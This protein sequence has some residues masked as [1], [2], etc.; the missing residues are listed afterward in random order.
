MAVIQSLGAL[1]AQETTWS[2]SYAYGSLRMYDTYGYDYAT[3]YKTQPNIRTCVDFLARNIAQLGLH[4]F[5]RKGETDRVRLRDHPLA[6]LIEQPLPPEYKVTRYH[7]INT[8]MS[9]L[10]IYFN[11]YWLKVQKAGRFALLRVP[12]PW[13]TPYGG[14]VPMRYEVTLA[15]AL[16]KIEPAGIVHFRGYNPLD[17]IFG[18]SPLE[19]L[20]RVLAEE[21]AA[22]DY[23]EHFWANSARMNGIIERRKSVV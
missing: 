19:T 12:P 22:G 23:R 11:A 17:P 21:H 14:I 8:L 3:L 15:G 2:P 18:L 10:G 6:K 7:L 1:V 16:L 4:V 13:V 5:Q 20:R 9:D